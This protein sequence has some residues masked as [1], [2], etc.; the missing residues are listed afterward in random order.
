M[1]NRFEE[2]LNYAIVNNSSDIHFEINNNKDLKI[3]IRTIYGFKDFKSK[4]IDHKVL[5][6]LKYTSNLNLIDESRPQSGSF[7]YHINN[8][9]YYLRCAT[10]KSHF[11]EVC[12]LRILNKLYINDNIFKSIENDINILL[13]KDYGLIIF[14]GP[15]GSGKTTS[16]YSLMQKYENKK[17][18]SI[19][20]PIEIHFDN[21]VQI[22]INRERNFDY[23][24]AITQVLRHDPDLI[25]IGE[26]R[27]EN[28]ASMAIR[29]SFT[30]HLVLCTIHAASTKLTIKRL[31]DLGV[32]ES[33]I[34]DNL[35]MI[36]NQ[37]LIIKNDKRESHYEVLKIW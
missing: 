36:L 37:R 12:V 31:L 14:S 28:A 15:T 26:I 8:E 27:D 30:G 1:I 35:I 32:S 4:K 21:I 7:I 11:K 17:I 34:D 20:D 13:E 23:K 5:E 3:S 18:Y 10:I 16:M 2:I 33:E 6:Y 25:C 24:E 29:A 9:D 22:E 19:E